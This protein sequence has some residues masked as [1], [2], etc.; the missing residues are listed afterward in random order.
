MFLRRGKGEKP[1]KKKNG[2]MSK[3]SS[4]RP[5]R[6]SWSTTPF[7]GLLVSQHKIGTVYFSRWDAYYFPWK[8]SRTNHKKHG[9]WWTFWMMIPVPIKKDWVDNHF[10][11]VFIWFPP[12]LQKKNEAMGFFASA[13]YSDEEQRLLGE[14]R[15][16]RD[17][18]RD[19]K[20]PDR[21][22]WRLEWKM[23]HVFFESKTI[24][25]L[26][27]PFPIVSMYGIFSYI[28]H[29]NQPN[30][31]I[32]T[33]HGSC[34]FVWCTVNEPSSLIVWNVLDFRK[35]GVSVYIGWSLV[36]IWLYP[37]NHDLSKVAILRT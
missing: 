1:A 15:F 9:W 7:D 31:G 16:A 12:P 22:D 4:L 33:I 14:A 25:A 13:F 11:G 26:F 21:C 19:R 28:Y 34:G 37:N 32:Y 20:P 27:E 23:R 6:A 17:R 2:E 5:E 8:S 18:S 29:K 36:V 10:K 24:W 35:L 3:P 30:V